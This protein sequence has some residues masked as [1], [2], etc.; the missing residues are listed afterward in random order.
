MTI[1]ELDVRQLVATG[2]GPLLPILDAVHR[3][4][5]GAALRL[6]V[7]F[8]PV[9]LYAKLRDEGF[10]HTT[11]LRDDGAFEVT[12]TPRIAQR[13]DPVLLDLRGLEPPQ[14]M[15]RVLEQI[16]NLEEG[17][18]IVALTRFRPVHLIEILEERAFTAE[19][20]L[21]P[22]GSHETIVQRR[23]GPETGA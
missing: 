18:A 8:E 9:P 14:P 1:R 23:G 16:E 11:L 2:Q 22:D 21:Q 4:P 19:S 3:L 7:P 17:G 10:D 5:P 20:A 12:F 15:L 13:P 6:I